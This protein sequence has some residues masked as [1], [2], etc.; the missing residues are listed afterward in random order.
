MLGAMR[1]SWVAA[2]AAVWICTA[3]TA[4]AIVPQV[5]DGGKYFDE[6]TI[7]KAN[8][9][10]K[11]IERSLKKDVAVETFERI[12]E[13][14]LKKF[15]YDLDHRDAFFERWGNHLAEDGSLNGVLVLIVKDQVKNNSMRVEILAGKETR[16]K[17]FTQANIVELKNIFVKGFAKD[18]N[19][20]LLEGLDYIKSTLEQHH[21][22][23]AGVASVPVAQ[24]RSAPVAQHAEVDGG[25]ILGWVCVGIVVLLGI[26]LVLALVRAFTGM[27]RGGYAG[28]G[29]GYAGGGGY[30]GG[31]GGGFFSGM[32]GGLF[33]AVAGN[34]LYNN[35]FGGGG[36]H[37]SSWGAS[38]AS[39]AGGVDPAKDDYGPSDQGQGFSGSGGDVEEGGGG[40]GD[41]EG[42]G[43]GDGGDWGGGGGGGGDWGGGGGDA[44]GGGGG[45]WGGG[46]GGGG[47]WGGGG[48]G[49]DFGGGGGGG[50]G[51]W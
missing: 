12:P 17:D 36:M 8:A 27:G 19:H 15:N 11:Q 50:G 9:E 46:G 29:P 51:D 22:R 16:K 14:I 6:A 5:R 28:G 41:V 25:G 13:D 7:A 38:S 47:D 32:L 26:W 42:G 44:G 31:G 23:A 43:G 21:G 18:H 35:M 1:K 20:T 40:G 3:A 4:L 48:G 33:G 30:G 37:G 39:A 24:A 34:W 2:V 45:D 49:G 10:I